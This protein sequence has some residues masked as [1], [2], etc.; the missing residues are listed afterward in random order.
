MPL[1]ARSKAWIRGHSLAGI[2]G[3]NPARSMD[4]CLLWVFCVVRGLLRQADYSP[5]GMLPSVVCMSVISKP[6]QWGGLDPAMKRKQI[7]AA[8]FLFYYFRHDR[9]WQLALPK[10]VKELPA[11]LEPKS[12]LL[13]FTTAR[14]YTVPDP[15]ASP[16]HFHTHTPLF[17]IPLNVI[18]LYPS[19]SVSLLCLNFPINVFHN[20]LILIKRATCLV[21]LSVLNS[22]PVII[23]GY[24]HKSWIF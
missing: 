4:V 24:V 13:L 8:S 14:H 6:Q 11:F 3:S 9:S 22:I 12:S 18:V 17:N 19:I 20:F 15:C 10:L 23:S 16:L 21:H 1:A 7:H 5:R 2:A